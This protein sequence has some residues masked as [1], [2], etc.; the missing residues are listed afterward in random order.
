MNSSDYNI[1]KLSQV[2][3]PLVP[4]GDLNGVVVAK[5]VQCEVIL[6]FSLCF[7]QETLVN[8]VYFSS[9]HKQN[10]KGA[11]FLLWMLS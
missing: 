10:F 11:M 8:T 5:V 6:T 2:N 3:N 1:I 4:E 9:P 7:L